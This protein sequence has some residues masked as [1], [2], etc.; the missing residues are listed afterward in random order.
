MFSIGNGFTLLSDYR[1]R[2][3]PLQSGS[4]KCTLFSEGKY[5]NRTLILFSRRIN[6]SG[7]GT[8]PEKIHQYTEKS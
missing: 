2:S 4:M 7:I 8:L 5:Q 3:T 6:Q 1:F